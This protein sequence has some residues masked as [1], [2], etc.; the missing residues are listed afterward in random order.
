VSELPRSRALV[1]TTDAREAAIERLSH[2]FAHDV[3]SI[4]EFEDRTALVYRAASMDELASLVADLPSA[5]VAADS[6]R[7]AGLAPMSPRIAAAFASVER[8][9][10][11]AVPPRLDIRAVFGNVELDL[12]RAEF[13]PG[14]TEISVRALFGN[15]EIRL[16][17][18]AQVENHGAASLGSFV[19]NAAGDGSLSEV[20][21]L[22]TGRAVFANIEFA[23]DRTA[24][25]S[26]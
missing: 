26:R 16:P 1:P 8:G 3:L 5:S 12:S 20:R 24:G 18:G 7:Q 25:G 14:V 10:V 13:G 6:G 15:V 22:V 23:T 17:E 9:G 21:V 11:V 2:A 4:E 19:V